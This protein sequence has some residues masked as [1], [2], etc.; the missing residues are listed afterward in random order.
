MRAIRWRSRRP[1][2]S[3]SFSGRLIMADRRRR[4]CARWR[5]RFPGAVSHIHLRPFLTERRPDG[6]N[7][8]V[9]AVGRHYCMGRRRRK[10]KSESANWPGKTRRRRRRGERR[11]GEE[12]REQ[13][14]A[15]C[16]Y[17]ASTRETTDASLLRPATAR[18]PAL[19]SRTGATADPAHY[20]A[21]TPAATDALQVIAKSIS[22]DNV[23]RSS[24]LKT[25]QFANVEQVN[26][27]TTSGRRCHQ[28][29][30]SPFRHFSSFD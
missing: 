14:R 23:P 9:V 17:N 12:Q 6:L 3:P 25:V 29:E 11:S 30:S 4:R 22:S 5:H 7:K 21:S 20:S 15:A 26:A 28:S 10:V 27:I 13:G 2:A 19:R 18:P 8:A 16:L 24:I 1:S